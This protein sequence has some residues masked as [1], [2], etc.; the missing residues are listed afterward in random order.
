MKFGPVAKNKLPTQDAA[1]IL[2]MADRWQR[3]SYAQ[4]RW[5]TQAKLAVDMLEGRQWTAEA[6]AKMLK[7]KRPA[8]TFNVIAPIIRL[9]LGYQRNNKSDIKFQP[10]QDMRSA[11]TT[12]E[13]LSQLEKSVAGACGLPFV[14]AEV[15][16]DGI[17]GGRGFYDTRLSF[18]DNDLGE[19]VSRAIDPFTVYPDPDASDYD[20]NT[21]SFIQTSIFTSCDEIEHNYGKKVAELIRPYTMGQTPQGPLASYTLN[22]ETTPIR[23]FGMR[24]DNSEYFDTFYGMMGDFVDTARKTIRLIETQHHVSEQ[25]NVMIDLETGDKATLPND[26]SQEKIA[27]ALYQAELVGN[28]CVVQRRLVKTVHW[29]TTCGD[30]TL[31]DAPSIYDTYT[32]TGYF[33]Y[34]RRG[35]TRGAVEDL[36][37]PQREKNK[38]VSAR[39]ET[40]SKTANG[41]WSYHQDS[42]TPEQKQNLKRFGASPGFNLEW[43]GEHEPKQVQP[44]NPPVGQERLEHSAD[45]DIRRISGINEAALGQMDTVQSGRALEARQR[46]AVIGVQVYM[47]NFSRSKKLLGTKHLE[48]FQQHYSEPRIYRVIGEKGKLAQIALNQREI[49]PNSGAAQIINDITVG[50]YTATVDETPLSASF[51]SAQFEE[52]LTLLEKMGPALGGMLPML[53]DLIIEASSLPHKEEWVSRI[54]QMLQ[55][56][57]INIDGLPPVGPMGPTGAPQGA[58]EG[59]NVVPIAQPRPAPA[60]PAG[61]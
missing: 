43:K 2:L 60:A 6:L 55:M 13:M 20:L 56:Q 12:A 25:R 57:G 17:V 26:W 39:V 41:G 46:Q 59:G 61:A 4:A 9:I 19:L 10:G 45:E 29:T 33:P 44:A 38:R 11:E 48:I 7:E 54:Q 24:E 35:V 1:R 3:A 8:L 23:H 31:F 51:A 52:M 53:S 18:D 30:V 14:D 28:P 49:D 15:F 21:G 27:K 32:Q 22:D 40:T 37:D 50:K 47:D 16:L 5:A 42:L 34:F 36:I 58:V